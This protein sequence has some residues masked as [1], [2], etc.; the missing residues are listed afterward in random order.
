MDFNKKQIAILKIAEQLISEKGF[1]GSTMR[2][3]SKRADVNLAMINYYFGSKEKLLEA[4]FIWK[5]SQFRLQ[6]DLVFK[7]SKLTNLHKMM[8]L[9]EA[10]LNKVFD[11]FGFHKIMLKEI[12]YLDSTVAFDQIE[13]MKT[14]NFNLMDKVIIDGISSGEFNEFANTFDSLWPNS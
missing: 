5:S 11:N 14:N 7:D 12:A 10:Y 4:L 1:E 9:T 2:E 8:K 3:I 6:T 13:K